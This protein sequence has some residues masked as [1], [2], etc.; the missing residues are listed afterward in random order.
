MCGILHLHTTVEQPKHRA[1]RVV[2][3]SNRRSRLELGQATHVRMRRLQQSENKLN[4][5]SACPLPSQQRANEKASR[6][7]PHHA[8]CYNVKNRQPIGASDHHAI[9]ATP[10]R[11]LY[12]ALTKVKNKRKRVRRGRMAALIEEFES[13][14]WDAAIHAPL[15][16]QEKVDVFY[17]TVL[18]IM[19][20]HQPLRP[21]LIRNDHPWMTEEIKELIA[22]RQ[23]LFHTNNIEWKKKAEEIKKLIAKQKAIYYGQL[24]QRNAK[25][26]WQRINE[27][28]SNSHQEQIK[29]TPD[30]LNRGFQNVWKRIEPQ[31][32]TQFT[33]PPPDAPNEFVSPHMV[34]Y[35]L[36]RLN[37]SRSRRHQR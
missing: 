10:N 22:E 30:E 33:T 24:D 37:T 35:Q 28:R 7:R 19:D 17:D 11:T 2:R 25:E 31:D 27:H 9:T 26:L 6:S 12:R 21:S 36:E 34:M 13:I 3:S 18:E 1:E 5:Y 20:T 23:C 32:L 16:A 4:Q 8:K 29:F 14:D 15:S